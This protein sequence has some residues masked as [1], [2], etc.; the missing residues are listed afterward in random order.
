MLLETVTSIYSHELL[1]SSSSGRQNSTSLARR[2][3]QRSP[4]NIACGWLTF[5][6]RRV[7]AFSSYI[8]L[9]WPGRKSDIRLR[10]PSSPWP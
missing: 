5:G 2:F 6:H 3:A 1:I 10:L 7:M 9:P 4:E 8:V